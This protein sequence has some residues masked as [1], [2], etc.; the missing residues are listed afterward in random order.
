[1]EL[2]AHIKERLISLQNEK[3]KKFDASLLPTLDN[4]RILGI[5]LNDLRNFAKE[6]YKREDINEFLNDL[7]HYYYEE[8]NLHAFII[9]NIKDYDKCIIWL[10]KF[11]PF[12]D[13]WST[14]DC[15]RPKCF[16]KNSDKLLKEID[17]WLTSKHTYI[18]RFGIGMLL[19]YYLDDKFDSA[20]L[21]RVAGIK[22]DE[23]Y[24]N[25]MIAWYFA[26]A[27]AKQYDET[28]K[29][30]ENKILSPWVHNKTIQKAIESRRITVSQKEYLRSLKIK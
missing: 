16:K 8:N 9:E 20:F 28:I 24:V 3:K 30:L 13:N 21:E 5:K 7:P 1:M 27:L 4:N 15:F 22:S 17:E 6:L 26:T 11:L 10:K 19:S 25:M 29:I 23:Y 18:I 12:I 2:K 14:C